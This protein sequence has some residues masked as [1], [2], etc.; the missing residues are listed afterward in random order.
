MGVDI[1]EAA[2]TIVIR[3][4]LFKSDGSR[5]T[6]GTATISLR[7]EQ[8]DG[9]YKGFDFDDDTL[10]SA[11]TTLTTATASLTHQ[12]VNNG[13]DSV[14]WTYELDATNLTVG[15][16]YLQEINH[17]DMP[18]PLVRMW[19]YGGTEGDVSGAVLATPANKLATDATGRVTVGTN[20]DKTGYGLADGAITAPK[21]ASNAI[22]DAKI[23]NGAIT[24]AKFATG[25][26]TSGV[27]AADAIGA[28]ELASDAIVEIQSGLATSSGLSAVQ[29]AILD[30]IAYL[31]EDS[32]LSAVQTAIIN[33]IDALNDIS[34]SDVKTQA[35]QALSD[36][37]PP[38][39][40]EAASD[41]H[42]VLSELGT[43]AKPGDVMHI[44]WSQQRPSVGDVE[45]GTLG[46][47]ALAS[48]TLI[49]NEEVEGD[50]YTKKTPEGDIAAEFELT[51][52][53]QGRPTARTRV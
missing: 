24:S 22:T 4:V 28:S 27:I 25:A 9:T 30:A 41:K 1:R 5:I 18:Q 40:S 51:L 47:S 11:G 35:D 17:P 8:G 23:N 26:I 48:A 32:D 37:D 14:A 33:A 31:P 21:I 53:G 16:T 46:E 45:P 7:E 10:K 34:A 42:E 12:T 6:S 19:Q 44:D 2:G 13:A 36:Y 52:D 49:G 43:V 29:F 20:A 38:T 15:A 39:R 3:E 50:K